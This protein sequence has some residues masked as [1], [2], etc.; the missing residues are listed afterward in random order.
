MKRKL[1]AFRIENL[2]ITKS[3]IG[4]IEMLKTRLTSE[5]TAQERRMKLNKQDSD[6]DLLAYYQWTGGD[7]IFF[8]MMMRIIPAEQ[9]GL[10][11]ESIFQQN[12]IKISDLTEESGA[13]S[14]YKEH[15][16]FA[17]NDSYLVT[18]LPGS[19]TIERL[20]T[21]LNWLLEGV[22]RE[23][24][25]SLT[26]VMTLPPSVRA[27]DIQSVEFVGSSL[28]KQENQ[29]DTQVSLTADLAKMVG[30]MWDCLF[31]DSMSWTNIQ[32]NQLVSAKLVLKMKSKPK[33][34][35]E[36]EYQRAMGAIAKNLASDSGFAIHTKSGVYKGNEIKRI[37][38]IDVETTS[39]NRVSEE[40]LKQEMELFL[41]EL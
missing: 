28:S 27:K 23:T 6:E 19:T 14:Q 20:Q 4:I 9:G 34:M 22:R 16:Y 7:T 10:L 36:A 40:H 41:H 21:Y 32:N 5:T 3:N 31:G 17:L 25:I 13:A 39:K 24:I 11:S 1:R 8:G 2:S 30:S 12:I 38:E 37:K 33:E 15:Y 29:E 35:A 26:P 18:D